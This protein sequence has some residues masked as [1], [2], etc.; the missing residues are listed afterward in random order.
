MRFLRRH[1][2]ATALVVLIFAGALFPL[3]PLLDAVTGSAP[4]NAE[5]VRPPGYLAGAPLSN[6]LDALTFL[7]IERARWALAVWAL[8]LALAGARGDGTP[9]RRLGR[10]LLGPLVLVLLVAAAVLLPRPVPRLAV[11][12]AS[13]TTLDYHAHT[14]ASHDGRPGWTLE[15]LAR[16]HARQGFDAAYVTDHNRIFDFGPETPIPLLPG[17]EWSV[18]RQHVLA[19]GPV[20][21]IAR[22]SFAGTTDRML[23]VFREIDRQGAIAIA[24]LPEYWRNHW[25]R[26]DELAQA[27]AH[28]FEIVDCGPQALGF[29]SAARQ[30]VIRLAATRGLLVVGGSDNHGWGAATCVWNLAAPG[31]AGIQANRVVARALALRQGEGPTWAAALTQPWL[32]FRT[33]SWAERVSWLTWIAVIGLYRGIPRRAGDPPGLGI[34]A[35]SLKLRALFRRQRA[36]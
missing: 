24:A 20:R 31:A 23:G 7:S 16:W 34:L 29:P 9:A 30:R 33:L 22:D 2:L 19:L 4:G 21:E 6:T 13:L 27:G 5:L 10:S 15:R 35:R 28:G 11:P 25:D 26:L 1:P 36:A 12:D 8:A 32:M 17:A 18:H 3:P 14:A